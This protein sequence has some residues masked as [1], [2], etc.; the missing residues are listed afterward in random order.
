M[1]GFGWSDTLPALRLVRHVTITFQPGVEQ[2][3]GTRT[4]SLNGGAAIAFANPQYAVCNVRDE[5]K[6]LTFPGADYNLARANTFFLTNPAACLGFANLQ[7]G[8]AVGNWAEVCVFDKGVCVCVCMYVCMH[9][10][11]Y[12]CVCCACVL[13][14][15]A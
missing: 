15:V 11:M 8:P 14:R 9:V 5:P 13:R 6:T 2:S 7:S 10:C 4:A 12:G 3:G 1:P